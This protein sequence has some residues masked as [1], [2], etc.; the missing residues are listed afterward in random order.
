MRCSR[1]ACGPHASSPGR[2]EYTAIGHA[3]NVAA[4]LQELTKTH[5]ASILVSGE[6]RRVVE[7]QYFEP[8]GTVTVRGHSEPIVVFAPIAGG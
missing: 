8:A 3:V 2:R 4:C 6:V 7:R 1:S 5:A